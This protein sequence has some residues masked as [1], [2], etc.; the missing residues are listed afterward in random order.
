MAAASA[1]RPF[2]CGRVF[3]M[4]APEVPD[5]SLESIRRA[6]AALASGP[7][8]RAARD[9]ARLAN[10]PAMRAALDDAAALANSPTVQA[11]R[12]AADLANDPSVLTALR[13]GEFL[14]AHQRH[15]AANVRSFQQL[16]A[17]AGTVDESQRALVNQAV[18]F[19]GRT[20]RQQWTGSIQ[21]LLSFDSTGMDRLMGDLEAWRS[22]QVRARMAVART[23]EETYERAEA[24]TVPDDV[25]DEAV[26]GFEEAALNFASSE[27][28]LLPPKAQRAAFIWFCG[29]L[30]LIVAMQA[31]FTSDA[32]D[33]V[34]GKGLE[35]SPL[36]VAAMAVASKAWDR[37][38]QQD[39]DEDGSEG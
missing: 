25:P 36:A 1:C 39:A 30:V 32:A 24:G 4:T 7:T 38:V 21:H 14:T 13:S 20:L 12:N 15:L 17:A 6:A 37:Y 29:A 8:A 35:Y 19:Y 5:R 10:S 16:V 22:L 34:L 2:P 3:A 26:A 28:R 33:A 31:A 18:R 27:A 23:M 11:A 9:A